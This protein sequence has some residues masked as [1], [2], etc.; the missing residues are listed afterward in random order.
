VSNDTNVPRLLKA[1]E[2]AALT[3]IPLYTLRELVKQGKGPP[4]LRIGTTFRFPE[5][6]VVQ[7]IKEQ[8][9]KNDL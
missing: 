2:L 7:W 9:N 5:D 6:S 8:V 1:K 4:H 3:G